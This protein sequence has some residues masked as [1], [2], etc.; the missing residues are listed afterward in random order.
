MTV[1]ELHKA[2]DL[3]MMHDFLGY[4]QS[5]APERF[6]PYDFLEKSNQLDLEIAFAVLVEASNRLLTGPK[7]IKILPAVLSLLD[8]A[9]KAY[10]R[11]DEEVGL[12]HLNKVEDIVF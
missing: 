9:L 3:G 4:V 1:F 2:R 6:P 5:Y 7:Y 10:Q 11:G 12:V 8:E